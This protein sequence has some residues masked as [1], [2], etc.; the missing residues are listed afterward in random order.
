MAS[1]S[2]PFTPPK[3]SHPALFYPSSSQSPRKLSQLSQSSQYRRSRSSTP[4]DTGSDSHSQP[5]THARRPTWSQESECNRVEEEED[6]RKVERQNNR[7]CNLS[8]S[9]TATQTSDIQQYD[10]DSEYQYQGSSQSSFADHASDSNEEAGLPI[11]TKRE[12]QRASKSKRPLED[13]LEYVLRLK[14][15]DHEVDLLSILE[16]AASSA[17]IF[18]FSF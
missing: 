8:V 14:A 17:R 15:R 2:Q 9:V 11:A 10:A 12:I 18:T 7:V 13:F 3:K 4:V 5:L 6:D 1:P 16:Y